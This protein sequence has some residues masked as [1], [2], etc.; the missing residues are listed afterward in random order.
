MSFRCG[1]QS[2]VRIG[3]AM[4]ARTELIWW[5]RGTLAGS[6][7]PGQIWDDSSSSLC[8]AVR[9]VRCEDRQKGGYRVSACCRRLKEERGRGSFAMA[10][11]VQWIW[12]SGDVVGYFSFSTA[13]L[14]VETV[15]RWWW[16][17]AD[18]SGG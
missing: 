11:R 9:F 15:A 18:F 14:A 7:G 8:T 10:V 3:G 16:F 17:K 13:W 4:A 5:L 1:D 6:S 12:S 2:D